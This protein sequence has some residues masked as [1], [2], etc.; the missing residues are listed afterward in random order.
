MKKI[1]V[2]L[3]LVGALA[4]S[5]VA[6][7]SPN[8]GHAFSQIGGGTV[9]AVPFFSSTGTLSQDPT[10]FFWD[11][12]SHRLGIG[13]SSPSKTLDIVGTFKLSGTSTLNTVDYVWPSSDGTNNQT[14]STNA[15]GGLS[16]VSRENPL[17]FT[18]PLS[19][20]VNSISLPQSS[21]TASGFLSSNDWAT[22]NAKESGLSFSGPLFRSANTISLAQASSSADG[23]LSSGDWTTFNAKEHALTFNG[24]L[25]RAA[26]AVTMPSATSTI[27]GYLSSADWTVFNAK[28]SPLTFSGPLSRTLNSISL[29]LASG[30]A[31]G[32]L[33]STDWNTFNGKENALT[34]S[35]GLT[36][37]GNTISSNSTAGVSG[38]QT[39]TGGSGAGEGLT[40]SSTSNVSKGK[41]FFGNSVYD[42]ANN[43][44][45]LGTTTPAFQ[46]DTTEMIRTARGLVIPGTPIAP[47]SSAN[48]GTISFDPSLEKFVVSEN[49]GPFRQLMVLTDV[50][51]QNAYIGGQTIGENVDGISITRANGVADLTQDV[52]SI[53]YTTAGGTGRGLFVSTNN[54]AI[55]IETQTLDTSNQRA[56][57]ARIKHYKNP[58]DGDGASFGLAVRKS[59][60]NFVDGGVLTGGLSDM[61]FGAE[62][63]YLALSV[64][65]NGTLTD[66]LTVTSTGVEVSGAMRFLEDSGNGMNFLAFKAPTALGGDVTWTLPTT[67]SSGTQSLVSNGAGTLSWSTPYSGSITFDNALFNTFLGYQDGSAITTGFQNTGVGY[68]AL[69]QDTI[70]LSNTAVGSNALFNTVDGNFNNAFG[71]GALI[72][73]TSGFHNTGLGFSVLANNTFGGFNTAVGNEALE[74]NITGS[75][76]TAIGWFALNSSKGNN[77]TAIGYNADVTVNTLSKAVAIGFNAK[78]SASNAMAL[79]GTGADAVNVG[80]G[81]AAPNEALEING[82][83]RLNTATSKPTCDVTA[84]G[85]FWFTQGGAGVKDDVE[86][87]AKDATDTYA[88]RTIY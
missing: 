73:N 51:L 58:V 87:C 46:L 29:P 11:G 80:I 65:K 76:N 20:V 6:W 56:I 88:W 24:P 44:L 84:R 50:T 7:A 70:G 37:I 74:A 39:L 35:S 62:N 64:L 16:W 45:G 30:T 17:T 41:I 82:G 15:S 59:D 47:G 57:A 53:G 25:S 42:E 49:G 28:E 48:E 60:G 55:P 18:G 68:N 43:R 79:G 78:V 31:S 38:G 72:A 8:P 86:V 83:M 81:T 23:Y 4:P 66:M 12:T 75:N 10:N 2:G 5:A 3:L 63:G 67:D 1:L 61:T 34:F 19:R 14:L 85:T 77:N 52:L 21:S 26:D 27:N 13:T 40:L 54:G 36:R 32:Y 69:K 71:Q 9:G 22:F 33:S